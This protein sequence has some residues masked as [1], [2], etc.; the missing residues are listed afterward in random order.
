[1]KPSLRANLPRRQAF[2]FLF[3]PEQDKRMPLRREQK[4]AMARR[5]RAKIL[6]AA[7]RG[8]V[9]LTELWPVSQPD[10]SLYVSIPAVLSVS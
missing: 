7:S 3:R 4:E 9:P 1:M 8:T 6:E 2:V 5:K 10:V